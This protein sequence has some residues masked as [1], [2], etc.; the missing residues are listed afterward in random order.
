MKLFEDFLS[1][2]EE[3]GEGETTDKELSFRMRGN[4]GYCLANKDNDLAQM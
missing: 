1:N 2:R 3:E 4:T